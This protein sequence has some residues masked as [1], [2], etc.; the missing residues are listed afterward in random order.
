VSF[1]DPRLYFD[2]AKGG[3]PYEVG[4]NGARSYLAPTQAAEVSP[5][6]Y[7]S[8]MPDGWDG[9]REAFRDYTDGHVYWIDDA[10]VSHDWPGEDGRVTRADAKRARDWARGT[11]GNDVQAIVEGTGGFGTVPGSSLFKERGVWNPDTGQYDQ[12]ANWNNIIDI[13][14]G[15]FL[16]FG[17]I[18]AFS[19]G[20]AAAGGGSSAVGGSSGVAAGGSSAVAAT[21]AGGSLV[22]TIGT[23]ASIGTAAIKAALGGTRKA[24]TP[25]IQERTPMT[26][27]GS[28]LDQL[29]DPKVQLAIAALVAILLFKGH[30]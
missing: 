19:G 20:A 23:A 13:G 8:A 29:N 25:V 16:T 10:G 2:D 15:T 3:A 11:Y 27:A 17:A 24:A 4:A 14:V 22:S 12:H 30:K 28:L 18:D 5:T 21:A 6:Y 1:A 9:T 7:G 26:Q